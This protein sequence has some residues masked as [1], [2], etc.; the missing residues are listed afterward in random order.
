M[1]LSPRRMVLLT[2]YASAERWNAMLLTEVVCCAVRVKTPQEAKRRVRWTFPPKRGAT[3][4]SNESSINDVANERVLPPGLSLLLLAAL[5][6]PFCTT[7]PVSHPI[8]A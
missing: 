8:T 4:M 3:L 2:I 7:Y 6:N 1:T 5:A